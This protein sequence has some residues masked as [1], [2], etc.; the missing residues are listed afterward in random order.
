MLTEIP[1]PKD[2]AVAGW[3]QAAVGLT[4]AAVA[5]SLPV[6]RAGTTGIVQAF[7]DELFSHIDVYSRYVAPAELEAVLADAYK[8]SPDIVALTRK[9]MGR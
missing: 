8:T 5:V 7:F 6:R 9:A 3:V 2:E 4:N 1:V